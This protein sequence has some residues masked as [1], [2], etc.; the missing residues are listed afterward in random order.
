MQPRSGDM[1]AV[2]QSGSI[3]ESALRLF[4]F[5]LQ[6]LIF[7]SAVVA[8]RWAIHTFLLN[9]RKK[10]TRWRH[11][12]SG[13]ALATAVVLLLVRGPAERLLSGLGH[14]FSGLRPE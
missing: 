8:V 5:F 7:L 9:R 13:A 3:A 12:Y 2:E 6:C 10:S 4:R 14:A 11:A 1:L